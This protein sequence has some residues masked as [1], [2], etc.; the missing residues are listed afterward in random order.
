MI[1]YM[2][3]NMIFFIREITILLILLINFDHFYLLR[4]NMYTKYQQ[5]NVN[6]NIYECIRD[7]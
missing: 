1:L 5:I 7:S 4:I 3:S 2:S 6:Y